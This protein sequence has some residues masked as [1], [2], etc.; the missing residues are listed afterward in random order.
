MPNNTDRRTLRRREAIRTTAVCALVLVAAAIVTFAAQRLFFPEGFLA[1]VLP[2]MA[3]LYILLLPAMAISLR[4]K[5]R[6]IDE[7]EAQ[8]TRPE[9]EEEEPYED[10]DH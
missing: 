6:R 7:Q 10:S 1:R 5:L 9:E 4:T 8:K 2:Y 3:M